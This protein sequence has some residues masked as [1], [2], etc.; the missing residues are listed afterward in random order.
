MK[1]LEITIIKKLCDLT[2]ELK[3]DECYEEAMEY[4]QEAEKKL[5]NYIDSTD[6]DMSIS[7]I[8]KYLI[9][10]DWLSKYWRV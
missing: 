10:I 3:N 6:I 4:Y 7:S 1:N 9:Y 8:N 5:I 2:I